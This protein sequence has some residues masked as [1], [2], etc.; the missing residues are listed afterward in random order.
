M[1]EDLARSPEV[2]GSSDRAF[3]LVFASFFLLLGLWPLAHRRP[4]RGW[5]LGVMAGFLLIS[6]ARPAALARLNLL[7]FRLGLLLQRIVS[8]VVLG[9]LFFLTVTPI[10]LLMRLARKNPLR[11]GFDPEAKSYWIERRPPGPAPD[12]MRRQF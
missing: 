12:T 2:R 9:L 4:I 6:L 11:L 7:W 10:G 8:P 5:A 1:H 3:G